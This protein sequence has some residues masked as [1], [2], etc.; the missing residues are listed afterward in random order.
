MQLVHDPRAR[1][2]DRPQAA[3]LELE[4]EVD[5]LEVAD[6]V[7]RIEALDGREVLASDKQA[8]RRAVVDL[9]A[10]AVLERVSALT[11]P[12]R[13]RPADRVDH[14]ACLLDRAVRVEQH[15]D[16]RARALVFIEHLE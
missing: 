14:R 13:E 6:A 8:R 15:R 10:E 5:V 2:V 11:A 9:S 4:R 12:E 1:L 16:D 7:G 3:I